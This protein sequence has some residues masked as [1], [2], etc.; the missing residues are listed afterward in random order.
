M[1]KSYFSLNQ[2]DQRIDELAAG[3][4]HKTLAGWGMDCAARVLPYFE[5]GYPRDPRPRQAL[6]T[7]QDWIDSGVFRMSVI[8]A[9]ALAAHAAARETGEDNP[10]RSAARA[11][12]QAV[13]AAHVA[14]HAIAAARYALQ[15]VHR[16]S[17]AQDAAAAVAA[18]MDWQRKR[19]I[20]R[21]SC[22]G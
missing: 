16:A 13:A 14:A 20:E 15:A 21:R 5:A 10:A 9:A 3:A 22:S 18:E 17:A 2:S 19:L 4:A 1:P 7:L 12:G 6:Q 8:R 11:A